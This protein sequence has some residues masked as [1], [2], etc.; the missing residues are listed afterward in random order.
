MLPL[1]SRI[2]RDIAADY[3]AWEGAVREADAIAAGSPSAADLER[4]RL[5]QRAAQRHAADLDACRAELAALGAECD[6]FA[7]GA[8][9]FPALRGHDEVRLSWRPGEPSVRWWRP[10]G[11]GPAER[12][13]LD[14]QD[15]A[16]R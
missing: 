3:G 9:A 6:G 7:D 14:A 12:R 13:P 8:I 2:A 4:L 10:V 15:Y 11:A 16:S 5:L 1:V